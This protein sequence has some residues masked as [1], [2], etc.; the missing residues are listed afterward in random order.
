MVFE[1][2]CDILSEQ[3]GVDTEE[4]SMDTRIV[5]DLMADSLDM[6]EIMMS[7]EDAFGIEEVPTEKM[8]EIKTIGDIVRYIGEDD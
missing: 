3:L 7:I 4:L 8:E 2:V 1:K 6:V 5:D